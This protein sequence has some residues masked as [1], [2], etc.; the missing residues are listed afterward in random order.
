MTLKEWAA[1][2]GNRLAAVA[3]ATGLSAPYV[4]NLANGRKTPSGRTAALI[5]KATDGQV[6]VSIWYTLPVETA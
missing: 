6:P 4:S 3:S 1:M 2:P 5:E